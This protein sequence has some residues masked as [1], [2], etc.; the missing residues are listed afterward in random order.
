MIPQQMHVLLDNLMQC[1]VDKIDYIISHHAE[2]D[3]SGSLND[4]LLCIQNAKI[5]TNPKCKQ[6]LID[7]HDIED[8]KF[9]T[10][11]D[12]ETLSSWQ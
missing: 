2:Q 5:V 10:V 11:E 12:G 7:L 4:I 9:V 1:G 3:H 6:M 8:D